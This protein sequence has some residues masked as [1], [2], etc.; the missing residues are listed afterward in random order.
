[1]HSF[2]VLKV[3]LY[4]FLAQE[5]RQ[6]AGL[7]M[8]VKLTPVVNKSHLFVTPVGSSPRKQ[9]LYKKAVIQVQL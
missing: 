9:R 2:F 5:N 3:W 7:K 4:I 6:K 1:M 8:M